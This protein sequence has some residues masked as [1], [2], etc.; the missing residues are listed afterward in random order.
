MMNEPCPI[1][2][3]V[4]LNGSKSSKRVYVMSRDH[5]L[6]VMKE[7]RANIPYFEDNNTQQTASIVLTEMSDD[8]TP[9]HPSFRSIAQR[10]WR[11]H[12]RKA[13]LV[14]S[15]DYDFADLLDIFG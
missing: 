8:L 2:G 1:E 14:Y 4:T 7:K 10:F 11:E 3:F 6:F 5:Y 15:E 9:D 13:N 12:L